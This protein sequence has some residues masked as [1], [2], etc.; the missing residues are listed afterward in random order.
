VDLF[1]NVV[2][3]FEKGLTFIVSDET[4]LSVYT[5]FLSKLNGTKEILMEK[6]HLEDSPSEL[7]SGME[8]MLDGLY[9]NRKISK[10]IVKSGYVFKI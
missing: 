10:E 1:K 7:A 6:L 8:I 9:L 5:E 2:L 3:A 4:P